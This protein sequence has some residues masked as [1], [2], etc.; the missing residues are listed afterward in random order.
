MSIT[1]LLVLEFKKFKNSIATAND[2]PIPCG[3]LLFEVRRLLTVLQHIHKCATV[4]LYLFDIV[5]IVHLDL[6]HN[7]TRTIE[8]G[9]KI[10]YFL[11]F[12][13]WFK[14]S[15]IL[16]AITNVNIIHIINF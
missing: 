11:D 2:R 7:K 8:S 16:Y 1:Q 12:N 4:V 15:P 13:L 6:A 5:I 10:Y 3:R 14:E 9:Y